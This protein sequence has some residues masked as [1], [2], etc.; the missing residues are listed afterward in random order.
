MQEA[1]NSLCQAKIC[2]G[3][4]TWLRN[5]QIRLILKFLL[6]DL[7]WLIHQEFKFSLVI[8]V[9]ACSERLMQVAQYI[10]VSHVSQCTAIILLA[11]QLVISQSLLSPDKD[12]Q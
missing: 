2:F 1:S 8:R 11:I 3:C 4:L 6:L 7:Y 10:L 12:K 9:F 5:P